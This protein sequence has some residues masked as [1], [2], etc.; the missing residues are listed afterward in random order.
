MAGMRIAQPSWCM[1][2]SSLWHREGCKA[3]LKTENV[4]LLL[5]IPAKAGVH[6]R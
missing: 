3:C 1:K 2:R 5:V 4:S 6:G